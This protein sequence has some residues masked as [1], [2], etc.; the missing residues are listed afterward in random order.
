ME[1][2]ATGQTKTLRELAMQAIGETEWYPGAGEKPH[3]RHDREPA[4]LVHQ[5]PTRLG[6][7][8]CAVPQ[9]EKPA[10]SSK[11]REVLDRVVRAFDEDGADAWYRVE[12]QEFLG[13]LSADDYT[14]VFDIVDVWFESGSTH[15]F[16]LNQDLG[17]S[18]WP[19]LRW[20][21]SLYLEGSDQ[22]RGWFHSSLLESCG[23]LGRA[24]FDQ[25]LT[26]G[27]IVD[28]QGRKM[29]KIARQRPPR[30]RK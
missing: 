25:V 12:P 13:P 2:P 14:Q 10:Q 5:P 29:S 30:R 20:P 18:E 9:Q 27:F 21:A 23:T 3:P 17:A 26:H 24:P 7:T 11:D 16:C 28:E 15:S 1:Q 6:R 4:R 8:D 19:E 22:H